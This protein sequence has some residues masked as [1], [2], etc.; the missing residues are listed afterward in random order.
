MRVH[1]F[2][3]A[4][5]V[6][7]FILTIF[8]GVVSV[9]ESGLACPDWPLC[10]GKFIPQMV[11]GKQYEHSH[12]LVA[13][14]VGA[15]TF[16]LLALL[17]KYRR[18]TQPHLV[19]LG[20][21]AAVLVT[22]Q[23]LLGAATVIFRLPWEVTSAHLGTATLFLGLMTTIA[24]LTHPSRPTLP[25]VPRAFA[26]RVLPVT[27]LVLI[28]VVGGGVMRHLRAGL[29]CGF[30]LPFCH[31]VLWP[32]SGGLSVQIHMVHRAFGVVTALAVIALAVWILR[33]P[34][35]AP[36][37]RTMAWVSGVAVLTQVTLGV[38]TVLLSREIFT[39]NTHSSLG[40]L[41]MSVMT[42]I[43]WYSAGA[44]VAAPAAEAKPV[45][46]SVVEA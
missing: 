42:S 5:A 39:I 19:K 34:G 24:F 9:T 8:G 15:M 45:A 20:V 18:K 16:G 22:F 7:T 30:D 14:F 40:I 38:M 41:L 32:M 3:V 27:A 35:T 37:L 43:Y 31:G 12:R 28:Q 13:S 33:Q 23:A 11:D 46:L 25:V 21:L 26:L 1:R 17:V 29:A 10:E 6:A 2:A 36:R 44:P 4:A